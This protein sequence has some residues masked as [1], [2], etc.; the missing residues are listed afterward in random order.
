MRATDAD[1]ARA[2]EVLQAA[3]ADGRLSWEEFDSRTTRLL[4][5][6]TYDQLTLL[7]GDLTGQLAFPPYASPAPVRR[8]TNGMAVASLVCGIGQFAGFWLLGTI[9]AIVFGHMARRQ[10]RQTG[11]GGD[12]M[13][14]AGLILGWAGAALTLIVVAI[15]AL[16]LAGTAAGTP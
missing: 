11:E 12:G 15:V 1:R 10:I 16:V 6:Q 3:Y 13:A 8:G 2:Q 5:A 9:P 14:V 4:Q 7:T